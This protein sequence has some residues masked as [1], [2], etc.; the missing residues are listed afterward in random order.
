MSVKINNEAKLNV[1]MV[2]RKEDLNNYKVELSV[3]TKI[4][5]DKNVLFKKEREEFSSSL[6]CP[7]NDFEFKNKDNARG[8]FIPKDMLDDAESV[9]VC[10]RFVKLA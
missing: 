6:K 10:L 9:E 1:F 3:K 5:W 2:G 7:P 8:L 4:Y